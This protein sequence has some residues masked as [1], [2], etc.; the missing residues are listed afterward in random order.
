MSETS[1]YRDYVGIR[2]TQRIL[3]R[4]CALRFRHL[5]DQ[6]DESPKFL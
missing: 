2:G 5:L 3:G 6:H 1:Y 4:V